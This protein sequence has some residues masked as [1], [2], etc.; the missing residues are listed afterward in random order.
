MGGWPC[1]LRPC[2]DRPPG[3][4]LA[5][6]EDPPLAALAAGLGRLGWGHPVSGTR[7]GLWSGGLGVLRGLV[8]VE[9]GG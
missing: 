1:A 5:T 4:V 6:M 8:G 7:P 3:H 2:A 9:G